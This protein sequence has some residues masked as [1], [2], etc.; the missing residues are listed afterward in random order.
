MISEFDYYKT[1]YAVATTQNITQ[2]SK[3][4]CVS[5]PSVTKA[6]HNLES[7]L[8][9]KLFT[10]STKGVQL[11]PSGKILFKRVQPAYLMLTA[12][13]QELKAKRNTS[14]KTIR[15]GTG[16]ILYNYYLLPYITEFCELYPDCRIEF[17][18]QDDN[19]FSSIK[20]ANADFSLDM[21]WP[22]QDSSVLNIQTLST[23]NEIVVAGTKYA[24]L[25]DHTLSLEELAQ[26]PIITVS[27]NFP[28][29][30]Y[31]EELFCSHGLT[32]TPRIEV[33]NAYF[34][35][36]L[37]VNN[38]GLCFVRSHFA[39]RALS[40]G[41][42]IELKVDFPLMDG[43][44]ILLITRKNHPLSPEAQAFIEHLKQ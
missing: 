38:L 34:L 15:I 41:S 14:D 26:Y 23:S 39:E 29:R 4:L 9:C 36:T 43:G 11:T 18:T 7:L 21:P 37:A 1:F 32:L 25:Q 22:I 19:D 28:V 42:L 44:E 5:Q 24:F 8:D 16:S 40:T 33:D 2:A 35:T 30:N 13:E 17:V 6:I 10:R 20:Y 12:A 3:I 31:Y 27:R